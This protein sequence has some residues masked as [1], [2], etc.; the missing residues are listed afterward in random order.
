MKFKILY[1]LLAIV[2]V[3]P[4]CK[5]EQPQDTEDPVDVPKDPLYNEFIDATDP[6]GTKNI[7]FAVKSESTKDSITTGNYTLQGDEGVINQIAKGKLLL[8]RDNNQNKDGKLL[9]ITKVISI[10]S[11][12]TLKA[13]FEAI[14]VGLN[15]L[16]KTGD[17][18][19]SGY[20]N[21]SKLDA[22]GNNTIPGL[23][24]SQ[25]PPILED[26]TFTA[27]RSG[28]TVSKTPDNGFSV[29]ISQ[30]E[31]YNA[32][33]TTVSLKNAKLTINPTFDIICKFQQMSE[34]E[35]EAYFT[36]MKNQNLISTVGDFK[37]LIVSRAQKLGVISYTDLD[38]E[39]ETVL[40]YKGSAQNQ[41]GSSKEILKGEY[42]FMAGP[43]PIRISTKASLRYEYTADVNA[44]LTINNKV[45][46]N[47]IGGGI[48]D[49]TTKTME[50]ISHL[51]Q[52]NSTSTSQ[53]LA[54]T[55]HGKV[56]YDQEI[57]IKVLDIVGPKITASPYVGMEVYYDHNS[58]TGKN[59]KS[60]GAYIS[61]MLDYAVNFYAFFWNFEIPT[62]TVKLD[63]SHFGRSYIYRQPSGLAM[64]DGDGQSGTQGIA[65]SDPL[66]VKVTDSKGIPVSGISVEFIPS[67]GGTVADQYATTDALGIA[68][69]TW[70]PGTPSAS[71]ETKLIAKL[72]YYK[73]GST[74][75][76]EYFTQEFTA[77]VGSNP[78]A[79]CMWTAVSA[80][81]NHT[82]ALKSD[83][84]LW[85]WGYNYYGQLG[86]G[87]ANSSYWPSQV[88]AL[89]NW[90]SIFSGFGNSFAITNNGILWGW[91]D[92]GLG[93]LGDGTTTDK[94][95]P[96]QIGTSNI[97]NSISNVTLHTLAIKN[98]GTLWAWGG[99][100][101]GQLGDGT[102]VFK[103]TPTQIGSSADWATI[104]TG[105]NNSLAIK[106][107][108]T[109]WAWGYNFYGQLGD[110]TTTDKNAPI[111]IG[112]SADW[113]TIS[114]GYEHSL[115]IK[116][117]GTLWAW[118]Y[119]Y[120][121]QLGDGTTK[122]K[123]SPVQ[124]GTSNNWSYISA[125]Y[126]HSL[127]IKND[128][129]LWAWGRNNHGQLG[130][131]TTINKNSPTQIGSSNNW[132][133]IYAGGYH[134]LAIKSDGTLWA[135]GTNNHGQLGDSTTVDKH[136]PVQ[137]PCP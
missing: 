65:L 58:A 101:S 70:L 135:W 31:L 45:E 120:N 51:S 25:E 133:S 42:I 13:D 15:F 124:I 110:G 128:G 117:D 118:G 131:G 116:N 46:H 8:L 127:A 121:G 87:T 83:G 36:K 86:D 2:L 21:R 94:Y 5:K 27:S 64:E 137:I 80:G 123:K 111:Q 43:V 132:T 44:S 122:N 9:L 38:V 22:V 69:T 61:A 71:G 6:D 39:W 56:Y 68:S 11:P 33:G 63:E 49:F 50:G 95:A 104:S 32:N 73:P 77:T 53:L 98:N 108:G 20:P 119:N 76:R 106:N 125:G 30:I 100:S 112:S 91:G 126:L 81:S 14:K 7:E 136:S 103:Q 28:V 66:K 88:G 79:N 107:D 82:L 10:E 17:F 75:N 4:S 105:Y 130:D 90:E 18:N 34:A 55:A 134:S 114:T 96:I 29:D 1:L 62:S 35:H 40:D 24:Y 97:W 72:A 60:F 23:F 102:T 54:L 59:E 92:N 85:A 47:I 16:F 93:Q 3:A 52:S 26:F 89:N 41:K 84:T 48:Y 113:A 78:N 109:L 74:P 115:A 57:E 99:N 129:T 67:N 37:D 19:F 12:K